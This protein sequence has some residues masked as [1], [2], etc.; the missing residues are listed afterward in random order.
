MLKAREF[1]FDDLKN[2]EMNEIAKSGLL[3]F[4]YVCMLLNDIEA[5]TLVDEDGCI[6]VIGIYGTIKNTDKRFLFGVFS[7]NCSKM[8]VRF[9]KKWIAEKNRNGYNLL[10]AN[11]DK[12]L[13][14]FHCFV[15]KECLV[16]QG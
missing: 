15:G 2:I 16:C 5:E 8:S 11:K 12:A 9:A 1:R 7:K 13:N 3:D 14:K 10:I 4:I 6:H